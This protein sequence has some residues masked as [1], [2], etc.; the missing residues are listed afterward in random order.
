M[1]D[2]T[3]GLFKPHWVRW[4][5][6]PTYLKAKGRRI[7]AMEAPN[8]KLYRLPDRVLYD[9]RFS[10]RTWMEIQMGRW[11]HVELECLDRPGEPDARWAYAPIL[12]RMH[13]I[14]KKQQ[15]H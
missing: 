12:K 8:G 10:E 3:Q 11:H 1:T 4:V 7:R 5:S 15:S 6:N 2:K 14:I 13:D 9:H